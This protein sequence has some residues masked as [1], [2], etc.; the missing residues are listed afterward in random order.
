MRI[1]PLRID[2]SRIDVYPGAL[3]PMMSGNHRRFPRHFA[4]GN[5]ITQSHRLDLDSNVRQVVQII[6][7][8]PLYIRHAGRSAC[9]GP[10]R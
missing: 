5:R 1:E 4:V 9:S 8:N 7:L 10:S 6:R 2:M 3:Q